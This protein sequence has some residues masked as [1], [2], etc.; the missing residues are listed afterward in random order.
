[1]T[2]DEYLD[3]VTPSQKITLER[4]RALI[5]QI[6]PGVKEKISYDMPTFTYKGKTV[7][8]FAAFKSH[9][10]LFGSIDSVEDGLVGKFNL[11]HKGTVQFTED[12][13]IP[14]EIIKELLVTIRTK[15]DVEAQDA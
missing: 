10:S 1:M 6:V 14:D 3:T 13:P 5:K 2:V 7:L 15:I 4:V 9:M 12:N 8:L 11:S